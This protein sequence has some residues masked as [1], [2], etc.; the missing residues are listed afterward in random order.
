ME[1]LVARFLPGLRER[2]APDEVMQSGEMC[3][4]GFCDIRWEDESIAVRVEGAGQNIVL[5]DGGGLGFLA[6]IQRERVNTTTN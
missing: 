5:C 6:C 1:W 2:N 4:F 3:R